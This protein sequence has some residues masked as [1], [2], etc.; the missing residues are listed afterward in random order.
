L[1]TKLKTMQHEKIIKDTR[2]TLRLVCKLIVFDR[3]TDINGHFFRYDV[4]CWHTAPNKRKEVYSE[5]V[6]TETE[7]ETVKNELW[8]KLKP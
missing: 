1:C 8:E 4:M 5:N 6:A 7:I 2:G 3:G